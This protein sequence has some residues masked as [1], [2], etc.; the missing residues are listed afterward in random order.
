MEYKQNSQTY[1][2][3]DILKVLENQELVAVE[4]LLYLKP[5]LFFRIYLNNFS[6]AFLNYSKILTA[7]TYTC[8]C[9]DSI[10]LAEL[11]TVS[12]LIGYS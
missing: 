1:M 2:S 4:N 6:E 3:R 8:T 9:F 10:S 11:N 7:D 12:V 5:F